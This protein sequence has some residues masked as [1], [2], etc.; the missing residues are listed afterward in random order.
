MGPVGIVWFHIAISSSSESEF[1]KLLISS[2]LA[3]VNSR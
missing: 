3:G 1:N 2:F